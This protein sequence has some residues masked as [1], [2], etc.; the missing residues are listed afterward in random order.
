MTPVDLGRNLAL[1][2]KKAGYTQASLSDILG[3]TDKAV[4]KWERG[5]ASPDISLLPK[6]SV[7]LDTDIDS[8]LFGRPN[9][10]QHRWKGVLVINNIS[11]SFIY[12]KPIVYYLLSNFLLVGIKNILVIGKNCKDLLSDGQQW[13]IELLYD[14]NDLGNALLRHPE[15]VDGG[16]MFI[17][18]NCLIYGAGLTRRYQTL[19]NIE[20]AVN[21]C[22]FTGRYLPISFCSPYGWKISKPYICKWGDGKDMSKTFFDLFKCERRLDRGSVCLSLDTIDEQIEAARYIQFLKQSQSEIVGDL[23]EIA[24]SRGFIPNN[25]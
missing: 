19:M 11:L 18:G 22:S 16:T 7:L 4:S 23:H 25:I 20:D 9:Y 6:L 3:I 1:L 12:G 15:F 17:Y 2:R 24:L 13:G 8:L 14:E 5:I 21:V 10:R